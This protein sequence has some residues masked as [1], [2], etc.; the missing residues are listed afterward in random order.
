MELWLF[1]GQ[2]SG[3]GKTQCITMGTKK[4]ADFIE[5]LLQ[6]I[7]HWIWVFYDF[8]MKVYQICYSAVKESFESSI[9]VRSNNHFSD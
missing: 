4:M 5:L 7:S 9:I 6:G 2:I 8:L 3:A 1:L